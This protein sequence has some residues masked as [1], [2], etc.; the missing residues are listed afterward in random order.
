M[1]FTFASSPL[2]ESLEQTSLESGMVYEGTT[3][4][5]QCASFQFHMNR[6]VQ[7][8]KWI[9]RNLFVAVLISAVMT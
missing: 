4:V 8:G 5:Y 2:S 1:P 6:K 3:D 9:L 7:Y